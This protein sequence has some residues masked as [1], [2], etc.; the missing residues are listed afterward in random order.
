MGRIDPMNRIHLWALALILGSFFVHGESPPVP[1]PVLK[2]GEW[3]VRTRGVIRENGKETPTVIRNRNVGEGHLLPH[4]ERYDK[5]CKRTLM[6][7]SRGRLEWKIE[8]GKGELRS[9]HARYRFD[10]KRYE[11]N[12]T[13]VRRSLYG[14]I[15]TIDNRTEGRYL[16]PARSHERKPYFVTP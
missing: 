15:L 4:P 9:V 11:G 1:A 12:V 3:E 16:G 8:C 2:S 5:S 6:R 7:Q 10:S 14:R 13:T